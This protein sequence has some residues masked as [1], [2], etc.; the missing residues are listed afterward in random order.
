MQPTKALDS[1]LQRLHI[2]SPTRT[3]EILDFPNE[4]LF[5][6]AAHLSTACLLSL[7]RVCRRLATVAQD[8]LHQAIWIGECEGSTICRLL[9]TF[10]RRPDLA[11]KVKKFK[12]WLSFGM[13]NYTFVKPP[14]FGL[15]TPNL[16]PKGEAQIRDDLVLGHLLEFMTGLR[17]FNFAIYHGSTS[18]W[19]RRIYDK[20][21]MSTLFH[22]D[23]I[24]EAI[25]PVSGLVGLEQLS[26]HR[27]VFD[28]QW[29]TLPN[30]KVLKL[31][32]DIV[33]RMPGDDSTFTIPSL[34]IEIPSDFFLLPWLW[35]IG[36]DSFLIRF[37]NL[38]SLCVFPQ[39]LDEE[40][41]EGFSD[42]AWVRLVHLLKCSS[43][44]LEFLTLYPRSHTRYYFTRP[45]CSLSSFSKVKKLCIAMDALLGSNYGKEGA[46]MPV[47]IHQLLPPN[48]ETLAIC[49]ARTTLFPWLE[50]LLVARGA[51]FARLATLRILCAGNDKNNYTILHTAIHAPSEGSTEQSPEKLAFIPCKEPTQVTE[52]RVSAKGPSLY[53]RLMLA[54]IR[55]FVYSMIDVNLKSFRR[56]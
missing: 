47:P 13:V 31:N 6:I 49:Y 28:W 18:V 10:E 33:V 4:V 35:G 22:P 46:E 27:G 56:F 41:M 1:G 21:E 15:Y 32:M 53:E 37:P 29:C 16:L 11:A 39:C 45:L 54:G 19:C 34:E 48:L 44:S 8:Q 9:Y 40:L 14:R 7:A 30:L 26:L 20:H 50:E 3:I 23:H 43:L 42:D 2:S 5:S 24:T 25:Q 36:I 12:I 55:T 51:Q 52:P 38:R 17:E